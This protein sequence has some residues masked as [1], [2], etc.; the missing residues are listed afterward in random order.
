MQVRGV[1]RTLV[2]AADDPAPRPARDALGAA[3]AA[4]ASA[5]QAYG[6]VA[7]EPEVSEASAE[8]A[9]LRQ[10]LDD[11]RVAVT[12]AIGAARALP[13]WAE[14]AWLVHG[15]L[16]TDLDRLLGELDGRSQAELLRARLDPRARPRLPLRTRVSRV[17]RRSRL[18][19]PAS[20]DDPAG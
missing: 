3:A 13:S 15:S 9:V 11:A 16:L 10:R 4:V 14:G 8:T 20:R 17:S 1:A 6:A 18:P 2:E 5:L 7:A 19:P 12:G